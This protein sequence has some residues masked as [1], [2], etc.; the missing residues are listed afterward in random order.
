M[1]FQH[2]HWYREHRLCFQHLTPPDALNDGADRLRE[3]TNFTG[4]MMAWAKSLE[5]KSGVSVDLKNFELDSYWRNAWNTAGL[6]NPA[7]TPTDI[8]NDP[9]VPNA[10]E[11][12]LLNLEPDVRKRLLLEYIQERYPETINRKKAAYEDIVRTDAHLLGDPAHMASIRTFTAVGDEMEGYDASGVADGVQS[13][14]ANPGEL[15]LHLREELNHLYR[16]GYGTTGRAYL[17]FMKVTYRDPPLAESVTADPVALKSVLKGGHTVFGR[18]LEEGVFTDADLQMMTN[19][20]RQSRVEKEQVVLQSAKER[21]KILDKIDVANGKNFV[22]KLTENFHEMDTWKKWAVAVVGGFAVYKIW[23]G[24]YP[25]IFK[26]PLQAA[27]AIMGF[28]FLGGREMIRGSTIEGVL[29]PVE[30]TVGTW[31]EGARKKLGITPNM[32]EDE[33]RMYAAFIQDVATEDL[34]T[35]LEA[36]G[37]ISKIGVDAI[38]NSFTLE[39]GARTGSLSLRNDST[40][41]RAVHT[42]FDPSKQS[43]SV[44]SKLRTNAGDLGDAMAHAFF[45]LGAIEYPDD[46]HVVEQLRAGRRYDDIPDGT[47]GRQTYEWLAQQGLELAKT[48]YAGQSWETIIHTILMKVPPPASYPPGSPGTGHWHR[49]YPPTSPGTGSMR[50][51]P[52][53]SPGTGTIGGP[54]P[55]SAPGTGILRPYPPGTPPTAT[56]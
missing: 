10:P 34:N 11:R 3:S 51:Y 19:N 23:T 36:M 40:L 7:G 28:Y 18:A 30:E 2:H 15:Q 12:F 13:Y 32:T 29:L 20:L 16:R 33:L 48:T 54:Y 39:N 25:R 9:P 56:P 4:R 22:K 55:P 49:S 45:V 26:R 52:P 37:Y 27:T 17:D 14:F 47:L 21:Q 1:H 53:G 38:S 46:F 24:N 41:S 43:T 8:N 31:F 35:Q 50:S 44:L 5:G 42:I 6:Y